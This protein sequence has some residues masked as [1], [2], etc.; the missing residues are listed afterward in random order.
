[1]LCHVDGSGHPCPH[2]NI[3]FRTRE[4]VAH[5]ILKQHPSAAVSTVSNRSPAPKS[6]SNK[7]QNL[8]QYQQNDTIEN[9]RSQAGIKVLKAGFRINLF[10]NNQRNI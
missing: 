8:E 10:N 4:D 7:H 1:M 5:H 2:C 6:I 9:D 3:K